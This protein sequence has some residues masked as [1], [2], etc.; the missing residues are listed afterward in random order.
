VIT[1]CKRGKDIYME[2]IDQLHALAA[3]LP[4]NNPSTHRIKGWVGH[5]VGLD[6]FGED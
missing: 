4:G 3:L 5:R 6:V 1:G 2:V